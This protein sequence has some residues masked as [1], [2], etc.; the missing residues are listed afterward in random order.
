MSGFCWEGRPIKAVFVKIEAKVFLLG[1]KANKAVFVKGEAKVFLLGRKTNQG[2][3][4]KLGAKVFMQSG[5]GVAVSLSGGRVC[6]GV[7]RACFR[8]STSRLL[9]RSLRARSRREHCQRGSR[10]CGCVVW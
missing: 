2:V 1:K 6:S 5:G 10:R 3:F 4:I 7:R 9:P 8:R